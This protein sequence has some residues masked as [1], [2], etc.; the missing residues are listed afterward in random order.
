MQGEDGGMTKASLLEWYMDEVGLTSDGTRDKIN[1]QVANEFENEEDF[2]RRNI[3]ATR[4]IDRLV[5][6]DYVLIELSDVS[7]DSSKS[8]LVVHPNF[9]PEEGSN[10][11]T[12]SQ[13]N[14][15]NVS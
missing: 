11:A 13:N 4:V 8:I 5:N 6:S 2:A 15:R 7:G 12:F 14:K 10:I 1:F 3:M 9:N